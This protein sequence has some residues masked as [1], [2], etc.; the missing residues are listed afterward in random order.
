MNKR[1][2]LNVPRRCEVSSNAKI[3]SGLR[4]PFTFKKGAPNLLEIDCVLF[5]QLY[6]LLRADG[7]VYTASDL[8]HPQFQRVAADKM[9]DRLA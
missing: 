3:E 2:E 1:A 6:A 8:Q 4:F 5:G 9:E 7:K